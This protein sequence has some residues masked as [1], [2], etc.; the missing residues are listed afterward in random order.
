MTI[1]KVLN[2]FGGYF[3]R[4]VGFST[5]P[6]LI[7]IGNPDNKSPVFLT[8]NFSITVKRVLKALRNLD[9]YLLIAPSKGINVWCGA[10]GDDFTT[11]SVVSIIKTSEINDLVAHRTLILPQLSAP[12]I[13]PLIIKKELGWDVKFGPVYAKNIQNYVNNNFIKTEHMRKIK[14]TITKRLEMANIY[15]FTI[16]LLFNIGFWIASIFFRSLDVFLFLDSSAILIIVIYGALIILPSIKTKTGKLKILIFEGIV[17]IIIILFY[18]FVFPNVFYLVWNIISSL[19][20][21]LILI[22]DFHGLTPIYK[23]ELG[24]KTWKNGNKEMK[25]IGMKIKLQPYGIIKLE[26]EKCIGCKVCIEVCPRNLYRFN[27]NDKK[28][29]LYH[30]ENCI[31]CNA[32]VKRCL[33]KCLEIL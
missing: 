23:S 11:D 22:E 12:G 31:N 18:I 16:F 24:E 10:C 3:F 26:R 2:L 20:F 29:D 25:F 27:E 14:F 32:C 9:C 13:D 8:C 33:G 30:P 6:D 7:K 19:L 4:W 5:E 17:L 1:K 21:A 28:I 15:F